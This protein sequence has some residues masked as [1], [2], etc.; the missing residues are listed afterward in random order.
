MITLVIL[1]FYITNH[2]MT[3]PQDFHLISSKKE[4]GKD[5]IDSFK[6]LQNIISEIERTTITTIRISLSNSLPIILGDLKSLTKT[7]KDFLVDAIDE[8]KGIKGTI[9][10]IFREKL[11]SSFLGFF[12]QDQGFAEPENDISSLVDTVSEFNLAFCKK[13]LTEKESIVKNSSLI[14]QYL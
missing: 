9:H 4:E 7:F 11:D 14:Q 1:L 3:Y 2:S 6:L 10:V 13:L 8:F 5:T 12:I